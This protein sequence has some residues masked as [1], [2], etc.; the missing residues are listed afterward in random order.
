MIK[1]TTPR[2]TAPSTHSKE[3]VTF[4]VAGQLFGFPVVEVQDVLGPHPI[5]PV[6][7]GPPEVAGS[8]NLR[9]RIVTV[10]DLRRRLGLAPEGDA[11]TKMSIV[12]EHRGDLYSF[13]VDA[14]GDVL[15]FEDAD[16]EANPSTLEPAWREV[17]SG[18]CRLADNLLIVLDVR[19]LLA[20]SATRELAA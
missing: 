1:E 10:M 17:S 5:T 12:V 13:L 8:L 7:L 20:L 6:P 16:R 11:S 18:I 3:Y 19:R 15:R 14:I 9:G 4:T 2:E